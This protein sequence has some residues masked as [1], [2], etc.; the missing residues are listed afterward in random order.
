MRSAQKE[1]VRWEARAA[2]RRS[3]SHLAERALHDRSSLD[4]SNSNIPVPGEDAAMSP[5]RLFR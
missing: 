1:R 3:V 5:N 2:E 4:S